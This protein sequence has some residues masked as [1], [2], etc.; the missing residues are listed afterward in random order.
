MLCDVAGAFRT[1]VAVGLGGEGGGWWG[2][3]RRGAC[4]LRVWGCGGV[5]VFDGEMVVVGWL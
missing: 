3:G 2:D 4:L 5:L 1:G